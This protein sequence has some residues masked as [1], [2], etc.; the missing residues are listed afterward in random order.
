MFWK[1][2]KKGDN[3][4]PSMPTVYPS[5]AVAYNGGDEVYSI[6]MAC[7]FAVQV[8]ETSKKLAPKKAAEMA[9]YAEKWALL[10]QKNAEY[11]D[12]CVSAD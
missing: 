5:G 7:L 1:K 4:A 2:S 12:K 8:Y 11:M 10:I 6:V 3:K 9:P